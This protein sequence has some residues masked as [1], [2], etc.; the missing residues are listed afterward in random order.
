MWTDH[1]K[2]IPKRRYKHVNELVDFE[3]KTYCSRSSCAYCNCT[4][5]YD[6]SEGSLGGDVA[7]KSHRHSLTGQEPVTPWCQETSLKFEVSPAAGPLALFPH[8]YSIVPQNLKQCLEQL[9]V[10][11][12]S[13]VDELSSR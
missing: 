6:N 13:L 12:T 1:L 11:L 5:G 4:A 8:L 2:Q 9:S 10:L 3:V 7:V